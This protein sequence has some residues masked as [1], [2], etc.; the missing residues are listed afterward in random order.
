MTDTA[1]DKT[2]FT[3]K[4]RLCRQWRIQ[5]FHN[6]GGGPRA[7]EFLGSEVCFDAPFTHT[8]CF[9]ER[10]SREQVHFVNIV[11]GYN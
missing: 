2:L 1:F 10:E 3:T 9:V 6:G 7:V 4:C 11:C 8:L 5:E